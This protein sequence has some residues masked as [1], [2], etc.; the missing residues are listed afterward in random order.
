MLSEVKKNFGGD[1]SLS[2]VTF[3]N[4]SRDLNAILAIGKNKKPI[5]LATELQIEPQYLDIIKKIYSDARAIDTE[6]LKRQLYPPQ[7]PEKP[8][9]GRIPQKPISKPPE[10]KKPVEKPTEAP[11]EI[12]PKEREFVDTIKKDVIENRTIKKSV[13]LFKRAQEVFGDEYGKIPKRRIYDLLEMAVNEHLRDKDPLNMDDAKAIKFIEDLQ[14]NLPTQ[15]IRDTE[16]ES[17]QQFSTPPIL[18]WLV[19]KLAKLKKDDKVLEPS[20]GN[21]ALVSMIRGVKK[22]F[23]NEIDKDRIRILKALGYKPSELNARAINLSQELYKEK[24]TVVVMNPPFSADVETGR[25][26]ND[27]GY[28]HIKSALK[29]MQ[30][31]GRLVAILGEGS[32]FQ[33]QRAFR[34]WKDLMKDADLKLLIDVPRGIYEKYGTKFGNVIAVM[35]K[36]L[37]PISQAEAEKAIMDVPELDFGKLMEEL[38]NGN[39][40]N[41]PE[42]EAIV[43]GP[44]VGSGNRAGS[45][46]QGGANRRPVQSGHGT[47]NESRGGAGPTGGGH[48]AGGIGEGKTG[49]SERQVSIGAGKES[50]PK[51]SGL[52]EG[53][54]GNE[55]ERG[56]ISAG[57]TGN[58]PK[59]TGLSRGVENL[60]ESAET[61]NPGERKE[62]D[63]YVPYKGHKF[64]GAKDHP[65]QL[66]E[67]ASMGGVDMPPIT[68]KLKI[69]ES[70]VK[71]GTLTNPQLENI[72]YIVQANS[73]LDAKGNPGGFLLADGTGTGKGR[74]ICGTFLHHLLSGT[75]KKFVWLSASNDLL[76]DSVE[77]LFALG[78]LEWDEEHPYIKNVKA[79]NP[80]YY[81]TLKQ[82]AK[83]VDAKVSITAQ[84]EFSVDTPIK[85]GDNTILFSTYSLLANKDEKRQRQLAEWM[86]DDNTVV[87]FDEAHKGKNAVN[88]VNPSITGQYMRRIQVE[89]KHLIPVYAS[90]SPASTIAN[91]AYME[92]LGL[93]GE[94]RVFDSFESFQRQISELGLSGLEIVTRSLKAAGRMSAKQVSYEGVTYSIDNSAKLD[95]NKKKVYQAAT[96]LWG[97]LIEA[98]DDQMEYSNY[99]AW[100]KSRIMSQFWATEL[101]F[102]RSLMLGLKSDAIIKRTEAELAKGNSVVISL[103]ETNE[104]QLKR[105]KELV[106][107][108]E[109]PMEAIDLSPTESIVHLIEENF[110]VYQMVKNAE[111]KYVFVRDADGNPIINPQAVESKNRLISDVEKII[112]M[113]PISPI[114]KIIDH[115]GEENVAEISGR[116]FRYKMNKKT[117]TYEI[118][119]RRV[120]GVPAK[121][122]NNWERDNFQTDKKRI[123]LITQA[124]ST[125]ISLHA[126]PRMGSGTKRVF[127]SGQ[128]SWSSDQQMQAFGRVHRA[129]EA[130]PPEYVLMAVDVGGEQR[131]M[132]SAA[133]KLASLN[134]ISTGQREVGSNKFLSAYNLESPVGEASFPRL[135]K[136]M[137]ETDKDVLEQMR[138][139]KTNDQGIR[140][141]KTGIKIGQFL[142]RIFIL[143]KEEQERIL[144]AFDAEM[145]DTEIMMKAR[146]SF[147]NGVTNINAKSVKFLGS[148][149]AFRDEN[150]G[151]SASIEEYEATKV[152]HIVRPQIIDTYRSMGY[153]PYKKKSGELSL[154][155]YV[156]AKAKY[157]PE[158]NRDYMIFM[159][160]R[161]KMVIKSRYDFFD[162]YER[163]PVSQDEMDQYY[164]NIRAREEGKTYKERIYLL[165]GS[166]I[167]IWDQIVDSIYGRGSG[168]FRAIKFVDDKKKLRIGIEIPF[169]RV[170]NLE[171][172]LG[173]DTSKMEGDYKIRVING[174]AITLM[175]GA[176]VRRTTNMGQ[177]V[178]RID[179]ILPEDGEALM[180][181]IPQIHHEK[182]G[183]RHVFYINQDDADALDELFKIHPPADEQERDQ[184]M[185][186]ESIFPPDESDADALVN[187]AFASEAKATDDEGSQINK[188]SDT[189]QS[190]LNNVITVDRIG[191]KILKI[192][193]LHLGNDIRQGLLR[194][195]RPGKKEVRGL[196][197]PKE[198]A[199]RIKSIEEYPVIAHELG[200]W[201]D[202]HIF[203]VSD[204]IK[205]S[206]SQDRS[207]FNTLISALRN[208]DV[209]LFNEKRFILERKYGKEVIDS[210]I[211]RIQM[212][213]ELKALKPFYIA[214]VGKKIEEAL[215]EYFRLY[216]LNPD[217]VSKYAPKMTEF[218][219]GLLNRMPG[220]ME[221][222]KEFR[223]FYQKYAEQPELQKRLSRIV[224]SK[225]QL[226]GP[227]EREL[228]A[229]VQKMWNDVYVGFIDYSQAFKDIDR[230]LRQERGSHYRSEESPYL[231]LKSYLGDTAKVDQWIKMRPFRYNL[232]TQKIQFLEDVK[233]LIGTKK[234]PGIL[235]DAL[236]SDRYKYYM[237]WTT[238][239][240]D[241]ELINSGHADSALNPS[242]ENLKESMKELE[243]K[244]GKENLT[245][246]SDELRKYTNALLD[247]YAA[248]GRFPA[249]LATKL[250]KEY[251]FYVPYDRIFEDWEKMGPKKFK[252]KYDNYRSP[253][254]IH[255]LKGDTQRRIYDPIQS[256]IKS[257]HNI[258]ASAD[259]NYLNTSLIDAMDRL[260]MKPIKIPPHQFKKA[261][262][263]KLSDVEWIMGNAA[264]KDKPIITVYKN[265]KPSYYEVPADIYR[266]LK[267]AQADYAKWTKFFSFPAKWLRAGAVEY[268]MRFGIRNVIR[269]IQSAIFYSNYGYNPILHPNIYLKAMASIIKKGD[270]YQ[271][272]MAAGADMAFLTSTDMAM[273]ED[274]LDKVVMQ[275]EKRN[276]LSRINPLKWM[277]SFNR[278]TENATRLSVFYDTMNKTGDVFEAMLEAREGTADYAIAG[279]WVKNIMPIFGFF[280]ARMRHTIKIGET[281]RR[282]PKQM[283]ITGALFYT[284]PSVLLWFWNHRNDNVA[285]AYNAKRTWARVGMQMINIP[286]TDKFVYLPRSFF[287]IFFAAPIENMLDHL[288]DQDPDKLNAIYGELMQQYSPATNVGDVMPVMFRPHVENYFGYYT[289]GGKRPMVNEATKAYPKKWW[290][291]KYT[292]DILIWLGQKFNFAP[293]YAYNVIRGYFGGMGAMTVSAPDIFFAHGRNTNMP[294]NDWEIATKTPLGAI[295]AKEYRGTNSRYANDFY[296]KLSD[297]QNFEKDVQLHLQTPDKKKAMR[298]ANEIKNDPEK[299]KKLMWYANNKTNLS[300]LSSDMKY[301][302]DITFQIRQSNMPRDAKL[303]TI[304]HLQGVIEPLLKD[305]T[306]AMD[307]L[308]PMKYTPILDTLY[309]M[310]LEDQKA[311]R[312]LK[313]QQVE[314]IKQ[315][316]GLDIGMT[317][318]LRKRPKNNKLS[319]E[320]SSIR[321]AMKGGYDTLAGQKSNLRSSDIW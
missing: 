185:S 76:K 261:Y 128:L 131:F 282:R 146:G 321:N 49:A 256:L 92:R 104:A 169:D 286:G 152:K 258:I 87:V 316:M 252:A 222:V 19:D 72:S 213:E 178:Y 264:P 9:A 144:A 123:A 217:V 277:Q 17:K 30:P 129:F 137:M 287:H 43:S 158:T 103:F 24:P 265:G 214:K 31:G 100:A 232:T 23:T 135:L 107:S 195:F 285:A 262:V 116:Q 79:N 96:H 16:Q 218:Y 307:K 291:D 130:V 272:F 62:I 220:V 306:S 228:R 301:V 212:R 136:S 54:T 315:K 209:K 67:S 63:G 177:T 211:Q 268:N 318:L 227:E 11:E 3:K 143:P 40:K 280:N 2:M 221:R 126:D 15:I 269:D 236:H 151:E 105:Q 118:A 250:K 295:M 82:L 242:A 114:D 175:N 237:L 166:V 320:R 138:L 111:G 7:A 189:P 267:T 124:A 205:L 168:A 148:E 309:K 278:F 132:S 294:L 204:F 36:R 139:L 142:N 73:Q 127:I 154:T 48:K 113:F 83:D 77:H 61:E 293:V 274:S 170:L 110:P 80:E 305:A 55:S 12:S 20:A 27:V 230:A 310:Y 46:S 163:E 203:H 303:K 94:G 194:R 173:L 65:T 296:S 125:G 140:V 93:W 5:A 164:K 99:S 42:R 71:A 311:G 290:Y 119:K 10:N 88:N 289:F 241:I 81:E 187:M 34:F 32:S 29:I 257:T 68:V 248:S 174:E 6:A 200:H 186:F 193:D 159:N 319:Y 219:D 47:S 312:A 197:L 251:K 275:I 279:A 229:V 199:V 91:M 25:H 234:N 106:K 165:N 85:A 26:A 89:N 8:E 263:P 180:N 97:K 273:R 317:N 134:A 181:R 314:S 1:Y 266:A 50:A 184:A 33:N 198:I 183:Y 223:E 271:Q 69:P 191:K 13:D 224:T 297:F 22:I 270:L 78:M 95:E 231:W 313:K 259:L 281:F 59:Q 18:A 150:T 145:H 226:K 157:D 112:S 233:P 141:L 74:V 300:R 179:G 101:R 182:Y 292:P 210:A 240:R 57:G 39:E 202:L 243:Q 171:R 206:G 44:E 35:D 172:A 153:K 167:P 70:I 45:E 122:I 288:Y 21:G 260:G 255:A 308:R 66:V 249:E 56:N 160:A 37:K 246:F 60:Q 208:G 190:D 4:G 276:K 302:R 133:R 53:N 304:E 235:W 155:Q 244:I 86:G 38:Q 28:D 239:A 51:S 215:A 207:I 216:L 188:G 201:L 247:F 115:F 156:Y 283:F 192:F 245:R 14:D 162:Q 90:A 102:F 238:A 161:G 298:Y 84:N 41:I 299:S 108:G 109:K 120:E 64:K 75:A 225:E 149:L 121:D 117:G 284:I 196:Y 253:M 147:D 254:V 176:I 58:N 52:P 98:F